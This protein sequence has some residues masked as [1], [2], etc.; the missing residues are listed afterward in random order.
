MSSH[1]ATHDGSPPP[2]AQTPRGLLERVVSPL[3]TPIRATGFWSAIVLPF[4]Y[5]PLLARGLATAGETGA[6]LGLLAVN[7]LA[8]YVGRSYRR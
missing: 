5:V 7:L 1:P 3:A 4:L 6:F 2:D 8:L